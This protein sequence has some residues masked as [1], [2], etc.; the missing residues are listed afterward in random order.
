MKY[1]L[2][3][4]QEKLFAGSTW[5][6]QELLSDYP[7]TTY[8]L[9]II[10]KN[11]TS[12]AIV[13][14]GVANSDEGFNFSKSSAET[15]NIA[16]GIYYAQAVFTKKSDN[17]ITVLDLEDVN[18]TA[19]LS[20]NQDPRTYWK[21]VFDTV[22]DAYLRL[23]NEEV[24]EVSYNGKTYKYQDAGK[25]RAIMNDA[26]SRMQTENNPDGATSKIYYGRFVNNN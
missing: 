10:I 20:A 18:I 26:E 8:N 1:T 22:R 2:Q 23:V 4:N 17:T 12:N 14:S 25:L 21:K 16:A 11:Y 6:W 7:S 5:S 24:T 3:I 19:L 15:T 9:S 13:L